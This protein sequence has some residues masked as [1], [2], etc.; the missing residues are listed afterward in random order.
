MS[1]L[2]RLVPIALLVLL[3][4]AAFSGGAGQPL[5]KKYIEDA[6]AEIRNLTAVSE[7]FEEDLVDHPAAQKDRTLY[8]AADAVLAAA[9]RL[10]RTL[11]TEASRAALLKQFD[12]VDQQ[13]QVLMAA[14]QKSGATGL[15]R[16]ADRVRGGGEELYFVLASGDGQRSA[17]L[18]ERQA[19]VFLEATNEL[20]RT[21]KFTL[22]D[23]AGRA[24][25]ID[26][27]AQLALAAERFD[28]S[29]KNKTDLKQ[30]QGDFAD[31]DKAW[32]HVV[33]G[34]GL[35][36]PAARNQGQAAEPCGAIV[37]DPWGGCVPVRAMRLRASIQP[38]RVPGFEHAVSLPL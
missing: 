25:T 21:S 35:L 28:K 20:Q 12:E 24:M 1:R 16:A 27:I 3:F 6:R 31:V 17:R 14:V 10:D 33:H 38:P 30:R 4:A 11:N 7:R 18:T 32:S 26:D 29:L 5:S 34:L 2:H 23:A 22:A 13:I 19:R 15:Q 8:R 36:K 37:I 9:A